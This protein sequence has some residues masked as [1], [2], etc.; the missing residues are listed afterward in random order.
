M[1]TN[2]PIWK[3]SFLRENNELWDESLYCWH[4]SDFYFRLLIRMKSSKQIH[5]MP[6]AGFV[7]TINPNGISESSSSCYYILGK[8]AAI[9]KILK[10]CESYN[11]MNSAI[12]KQSDRF[13]WL[14]FKDAV[15]KHFDSVLSAIEE[16]HKS[17]SFVQKIIYLIPPELLRSTYKAI[18]FY[19]KTILRR[20]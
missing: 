3:T 10:F 19:R 20:G 18:K 11:L 4:E 13:M 16:N 9:K 14:M 6:I 2:M 17:K 15:L 5:H 7:R 8:L 12:R 1:N